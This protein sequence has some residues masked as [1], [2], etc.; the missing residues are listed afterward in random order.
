MVRTNSD[1]RPYKNF[2]HPTYLLV[3]LVLVLVLVV[4]KINKRSRN[5][6]PDPAKDVARNPC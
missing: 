1:F 2:F 6:L 4:L 5:K 3:A